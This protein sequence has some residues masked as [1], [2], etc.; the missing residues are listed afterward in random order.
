MGTAAFERGRWN[1]QYDSPRMVDP[2]PRF[3]MSH[4][5]MN[6]SAVGKSGDDP[7]Y[8]VWLNLRNPLDEAAASQRS[9]FVRRQPDGPDWN[10]RIVDG[11][12]PRRQPCARSRGRVDIQAV[13]TCLGCHPLHYP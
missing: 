7:R 4:Q 3:Q 1:A 9:E 12:R 6:R 10:I 11:S 5:I 8:L 2:V 13:D